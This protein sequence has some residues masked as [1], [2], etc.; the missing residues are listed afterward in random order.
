[1]HEDR[2]ARQS[3]PV[4]VA[5]EREPRTIVSDSLEVATRGESGVGEAM[6]KQLDLGLG[7]MQ[8]TT[9]V[10]GQEKEASATSL[11]DCSGTSQGSASQRQQ[12]SGGGNSVEY[13]Q[14]SISGSHG[15]NEEKNRG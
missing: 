4:L 15:G 6:Q 10:L 2:Q 7:H 12:E 8:Q 1:M 5:S 14:I 13:I 3:G 9:M 11:S